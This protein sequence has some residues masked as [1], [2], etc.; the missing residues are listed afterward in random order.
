MNENENIHLCSFVRFFKD[1]AGQPSLTKD[2]QTESKKFSALVWLDR[3]GAPGLYEPNELGFGL[4]FKL[5]L[6]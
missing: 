1:L 2:L 3:R 6:E 5:G 4:D